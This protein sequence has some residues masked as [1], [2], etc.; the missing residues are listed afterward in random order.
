M[1][2]ALWVA[3][4]MA[5]SAPAI[6]Q[7]NDPFA[8]GNA[9]ARP[10]AA[11]VDVISR[12]EFVD[13]PITEIFRMISDLT[14]WSIILS[15]DLS[16]TP[17]DIDLWI[18][19]LPP[20][21]VLEE[22]ERVAGV[23][24]EREGTIVRVFTFDEY[25]RDRGVEKQLVEVQHA[26]A[27]AI[28]SALENFTEEQ[29]RVIA[30]E[31]S[32]QVIILAPERLMASLLRL[33]ERLDVPRARD[34]VQIVP[35]QHLEA[36]NVVE[37]LEEFLQ[38]QAG[39]G[40]PA[41][42]FREESQPEGEAEGEGGGG[43]VA[44]GRWM[45]RFAAEPRLNV[46]VLR[47]LQ[48]DVERVVELI[49]E[50]DVEAEVTVEGYQLEFT[51]AA[52]VHATLEQ[53]LREGRQ[54][55][56]TG[57]RGEGQR[58]RQPRLRV[59]LSEQNNRIIVEGGPEDHRRVRELLDAVDQPLPPGT[60]GFRVYRLENASAEE[61]AAV[62]QSMAGEDSGADS[63]RR[64]P[65]DA[66]TPI[67]PRIEP[68]LTL[69]E[70]GPQPPSEG[71]DDGE[72][73]AGD[74]LPARITAATEINA[75]IIRASAAEQAEFADVID[76]LDQ[77]R[78]QV[79]LEVMLVSVRND[80]G[81]RLGVE[82]SGAR[83]NG[84]STEMIGLSSF[85]V[86]E[87]DPDT[88]DLSFTDPP[89]FGANFGIF[90]ANDLSLVVNA[91]RT[92]GETRITSNPRILVQDNSPAEITQVSEEPYEAIS[93]SDGTVIRSFGGFVSAG[94]VLRVTPHVS[95]DDWLRLDYEIELSSFGLRSAE[96]R[97]ANLPPPRRESA[98]Q[99]TVRL[100]ADHIVVVGGLESTDDR[101]EESRVPLLGDIPVLGE[102]FKSRQNDRFD[103]TLYIFIRPRLLQDPDFYDLI[104]LSEHASREADV[105]PEG[106][107]NPPKLFFDNSPELIQ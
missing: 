16:D 12:V 13:A 11:D 57:G 42:V 89:P 54:Q 67:E 10:R 62:L 14:G 75:V 76:E 97:S 33:A 101:E 81:F 58:D 85:G 68:E 66:D 52:D 44:G 45:V 87:V 51:R 24:I 26:S 29:T 70:T 30:D 95:D 79:L 77:P 9:D 59:A 72:G 93:Q 102:L 46:I 60:G 39:G 105:A 69:P 8:P 74:V 86:S 56:R 18:R 48:G 37:I 17:P 73:T 80:D 91:L 20:D 92:I 88:G 1:W 53:V 40:E 27:S 90:N 98:S 4:L 63:A 21:E 107:V 43:A 49:E 28:V 96:Q 100:P 65:L 22:V 55:G 25:A 64:S 36:D 83:I 106:P 34:E 19:N 31:G 47:G 2:G 94:T 23:V 35:L 50:L 7:Q 15:P 84:V 82:L 32:N 103:E 71:G 41:G 6:A 38:E 61:V 5:V 104:H 99:G 78:D 3:G